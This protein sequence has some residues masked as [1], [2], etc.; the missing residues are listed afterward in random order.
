MAFALFHRSRS[1][2]AQVLTRHRLSV[3]IR[4]DLNRLAPPR[5]ASF[6][7][8]TS[9]GRPGARLARQFVTSLSLDTTLAPALSPR[10]PRYHVL[11]RRAHA[12]VPRCRD[13]PVVRSF[14]DERDEEEDDLL[15]ARRETARK[16]G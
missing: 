3:T 7:P 1:T 4:T 5:E 9:R 2:G 10:R 16:L 6:V 15:D 11:P 12:S 13:P 8:S 14:R